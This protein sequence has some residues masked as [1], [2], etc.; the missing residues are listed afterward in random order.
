MP[1]KA[2]T[3][4]RPV[5]IVEGSDWSLGEGDGATLIVASSSKVLVNDISLEYGGAD[6][7]SGL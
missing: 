5:S 6:G 2:N 7:F 3:S 4:S 1:M